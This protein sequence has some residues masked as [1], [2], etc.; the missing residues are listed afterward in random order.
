MSFLSPMAKGRCCFPFPGREVTSSSERQRAGPAAAGQCPGLLPPASPLTPH[1]ESARRQVRGALISL[2]CPCQKHA[3]SSGQACGGTNSGDR[4]VL[5]APRA[6]TSKLTRFQS[7]LPGG[8][9]RLLTQPLNP[10]APGSMGGTTCWPGNH[11]AP[12]KD[13]ASFT[14]WSS[15]HPLLWGCSGLG[16]QD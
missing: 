16:L 6:V 9:P 7:H 3:A 14:P 5:Q 1:S 15:L 12:L 11:L 13:T 2:H 4:A 8:E 10:G